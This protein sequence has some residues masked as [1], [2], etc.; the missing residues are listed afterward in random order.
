MY[1]SHLL[2][3]LPTTA[4]GGKTPLE[5]WSGGVA[6]DHGMFRVFGYLTYI[7]VKKDMLD[8]KLNELVF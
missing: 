4:I 3:K 5:I 1:A 7:N 2:N 8:S 6:R